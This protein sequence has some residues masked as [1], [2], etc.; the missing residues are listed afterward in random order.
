MALQAK[1]HL[2]PNAV[3]FGPL[4]VLDFDPVTLAASEANTT[5]QR[6]VALPANCKILRVAAL[7][8]D[9]V[10]GTCSVNVVAGSGA[11]AG[12]G[13]K[14]TL[15]VNGT[16]VLSADAALTMTALLAQEFQ[17]SVPDTIYPT[18]LPLTIRVATGSS[19]TGTLAVRVLAQLVDPN[20]TKPL[21]SGSNFSF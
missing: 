20:P 5:V 13:T 19:T 18:S 6:A 2:N 14:D 11:E 15:A 9:T 1:E 7:L 8:N 3:S 4:V 16:Q 12:V 17:A 10:A 21:Y